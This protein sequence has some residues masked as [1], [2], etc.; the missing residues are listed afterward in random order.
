LIVDMIMA[1]LLLDTLL[2]ELE[3]EEEDDD[4]NEKG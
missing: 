3:E 2:H 1:I 4:D